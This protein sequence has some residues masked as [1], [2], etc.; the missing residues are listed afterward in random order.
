MPVLSSSHTSLYNPVNSS[1][2]LYTFKLCVKLNVIYCTWGGRGNPLIIILITTASIQWSRLFTYIKSLKTYN[3]MTVPLLHMGKQRSK[4]LSQT[5]ANIAGQWQSQVLNSIRLV[6]L[7][8]L[9]LSLLIMSQ[10]LLLKL[11]LVNSDFLT[12]VPDE[13]HKKI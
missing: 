5:K 4:R 2:A 8:S 1:C 6:C 11:Y 13:Y 3:L 10:L 7:E 12:I 9:C